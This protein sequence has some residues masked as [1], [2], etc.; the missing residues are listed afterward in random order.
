MRLHIKT[1]QNQ[2][3]IPFDYQQKLTGVLHKWLGENNQE[4]GE[5]SLYSF[6]WLRN[7]Q[8]FENG[9][10][11]P[12]GA[13]FFLSFYDTQRLKDV[14]ANIRKEPEVFCGMCVEDVVIEDTPDLTQQEQFNLGSPILIKRKE[15][16][17]ITEFY[18]DNLISGKLLEE[19]L[20][21]KMKLAGIPDDDTLS[22][23]FNLS[24]A[25]KKTK[26]VWYDNISNKANMC[27]VI[28]KGSNLTKQF[29]WN[30]GLG[31]STG[32]GFGSIY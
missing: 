1:S 13:S 15:N 30:V 11:C 26:L 28:I 19:T 31:N 32:V 10:I 23:A 22:I 14:L 21:T 8:V 25:K 6:S 16:D 20:R 24:Y 18:Y 29:A 2:I 9:L 3:K 4:H 5:I 12:K 27:P 7:T 17:K